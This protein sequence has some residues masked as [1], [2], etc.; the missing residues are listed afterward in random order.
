MPKIELLPSG[1]VIE[2]PHGLNVLEA[3]R[4]AGLDLEAPC[5]G[6]GTCG[7]CIVRLVHGEVQ[8]DS[9]GRLP[10]PALAAGYVLACRTRLLSSPV[11]VEIPEHEAEEE[12]QFA[13]SETPHL[14][15]PELLPRAQDLSPLAAKST[16]RVPAAQLEDG[17]SDLDR[18]T[19]ALREQCGCSDVRYALAAMRSAAE[20]LRAEDGRVSVTFTPGP[21]PRVIAVEAGDTASRHFG[22]AVDLGTT[23]VAVQ[24]VDLSGGQILAT[25]SDYN[26]QI[27]LGVDVI[28]RINSAARPGGLEELRTRALETINDL[29]CAA[30]IG[31]AVNPAEICAAVVSGNTVMTHLLLG[32]V[33]EHIRR[34]P[35]TPTVKELPELSA[36]EVGLGIGADARVRVSPCVGSYVG[37]D[38][39]A[40]LLCT[41]LAQG[42]DTVSL[43]IDIGTN[44][45]LVIGN[46]EFLMSCA[47]SAGPAFEG[48]GIRGGMRAATGAIEKVTIERDSAR[49]SCSTI[50]GGPARGIC[51]S[52]L[53][54]LLANLLRS[55]W[56]DRR[57]SLDRSRDSAHVTVQGKGARFVL[58]AAEDSAAGEAITISETEIENVIRA[59]AAIYS[60]T[61]LMM[62]QVGLS[63][64][65]LGQVYVAG[66][67]GR[68]LDLDQAI[69]IGMLPDIPRDRFRYLGNAS[70]MGSYLALV[71]QDRRRRQLELARRMT[72]IELS[73]DPAYMDQYTAALF[74]PHT[75]LTLFPSL[76][77]PA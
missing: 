16:L 15:D 45:E 49:P 44:G 60:A 22:L 13:D 54:D 8:G 57:G 47:C 74:L 42:T 27:P 12:G 36:S 19:R 71:A 9:V 62:K 29:L 65:D 39:T 69:R 37:G 18:V 30:A 23:S 52:G 59:K 76:G 26:A 6:D 43:Y 11:V 67:F 68:F 20:A 75:D 46:G 25:H 10:A 34:E 35:Y 63:L 3:T 5:G 7:R 70:L 64:S 66:S 31:H 53:I 38:I 4:E 73:T 21:Q 77:D 24:L 33:P 41:P 72:Y 28:S 51:G 50:G 17:L 1:Q 40:G 32:L 14:V 56:I 61:T 58:V 2:L 55:G 48:G